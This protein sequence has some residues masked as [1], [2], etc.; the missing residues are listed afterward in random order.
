MS[1]VHLPAKV[2]SRDEIARL[3]QQGTE[4]EEGKAARE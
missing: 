1:M 2:L 4:I 3:V